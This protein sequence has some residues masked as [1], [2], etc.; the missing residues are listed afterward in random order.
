VAREGLLKSLK[1][2]FGKNINDVSILSEKAI[3]DD[4]NK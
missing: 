3:I 4:E 1:N 2:K